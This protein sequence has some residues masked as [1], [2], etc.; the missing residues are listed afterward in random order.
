MGIKTGLKALVVAQAYIFF[1][2]GCSSFQISQQELDEAAAASRTNLGLV[3]I[4]EPEI[5]E[6][7]II[8]YNIPNLAL[9]IPGRVSAMGL[10]KAI[11][12]VDQA[13]LNYNL[14]STIRDKNFSIAEQ[15]SDDLKTELSKIGYQVLDA[16]A[17][18]HRHA[19][20]FRGGGCLVN[21]P[22]TEP[23]S[24]YFLHIV[25]D[26]AGY[27]SFSHS[28]PFVPLMSVRLQLVST[29]GLAHKTPVQENW[30]E[31]QAHEQGPYKVL[32]SATFTYGG[33]VPVSGPT[34]AVADPGLAIRSMDDLDQSDKVIRGLKAAS[35]AIAEKVAYNMR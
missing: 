32:Y 34:D 6:A 22:T 15:L 25:I 5:Y 1:L 20:E 3:T 31:G 29:T 35:A 30:H 24:D 17:E 26:Y 23:C 7:K 33:P 21:P 28:Q 12:T 27:T 11:K 2:L 16:P 8:Q 4:R 19:S 10:I 14:T 13:N 18:D 9:T